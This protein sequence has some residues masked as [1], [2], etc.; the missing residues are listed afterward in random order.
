MRG[1][2]LAGGTGSRLRPLTYTSAKQLIP[3]ANRPILFYV[4]ADLARA[5]IQDVGIIVAPTTGDEIRAAVG[6]GSTFGLNVQY[7]DQPEPLGLAHAVLTAEWYLAGEPFVM[8]LG[9]NLLQEGVGSLVEEFEREKP[10]ASILL[11]PVPNP[12]AFGVAELQGDRVVRL[13]EKPQDP[14]SNLALVGVYLFDRNIFDA[15]RA[16]QP[17]WRGELE[18]TDA[19]Q[20]MVTAGLD[21]R[22]HLVRGWWLDT[23]KKDDM[24]EANR[25]VL[26]SIPPRMEGEVDT[27][28]RIEGRVVVEA[29]ATILR[30][31]VRGPAVIGAGARVTDSYIG[32]FTAVGEGC[33]V[34]SSEVEHSILMTDSQVSGVRRVSDS[35]LGRR[36]VV[37]RDGSSPVAYRFMIGDQST[38]GV[39]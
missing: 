2:V 26:E 38:V 7:I 21:V 13:V 9:D 33:V 16:I 37:S 34:E 27:A 14:P 11:T 24:L 32:P 22:P 31:H 17:S 10:N 19:I 12:Q 35:I 30:S 20:H 36:S 18:I 5:G 25:T 28:S 39:V 29:G 1:L 23:G 3:V 4:L 15:A 8:Y 6:D